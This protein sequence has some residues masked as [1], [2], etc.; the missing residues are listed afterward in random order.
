MIGCKPLDFFVLLEPCHL[1]FRVAPNGVLEVVEHLFFRNLVLQV[2]R[3]PARLKA[4]LVQTLPAHSAF[5]EF[6]YFRDH[7]GLH[8]FKGGA[9]PEVAREVLTKNL[10]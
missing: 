9:N 6:F 10:K 3:D 4:Q 8:P 1:S 2:A 5:A 7:S